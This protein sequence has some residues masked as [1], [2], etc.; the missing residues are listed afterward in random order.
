MIDVKE[1]ATP[2]TVTVSFPCKYCNMNH[3]VAVPREIF[4]DADYPVSYI[5][6]HGSPQIVATLHIDA[7]FK[8]RGVEYA[9]GFGVNKDELNDILNK[10]KCLCL[11]SIPQEMLFA[12]QL[13]QFG[14]V[15]KFFA[16][17]GY[18][19]F[20]NFSGIHKIFKYS[21]KLVRSKEACSELFIKYSDFWIGAL[22]MFEFTFILIADQSIDLEHL[23]TQMMAI[24]ETIV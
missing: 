19:K 15:S 2:E 11:T 12:F 20:F 6:I 13:T 14:K 18:E 4:D 23:K 24:F 21:N 22:E 10:S 5:F 8:V 9:Q 3:K 1:Y 17:D 7:N 16:R